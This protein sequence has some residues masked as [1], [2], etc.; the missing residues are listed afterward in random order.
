MIKNKKGQTAL[1]LILLTAV[2]LVFL[3]ITLNWGR[4]AQTKALLT[5]AAD[6]TASLLA[7]D[8]A[9]YGEMWKQTY[10]GNHNRKSNIDYQIILDIILVVIAI[11]ITITTYGGAYGLAAV[12]LA[13]LVA[14]LV[15]QLAVIQPGME[16]MWNKQ[17][18]DQP[19]YQQFYEGGITQALQSI[20]AD[21]VN[22][23]DYF[24]SNSNGI[25]GVN[26]STNPASPNDT[27]NRFAFFYNERLKMLNQTTSM[28]QVGFFYNQLGEFVNGESCL[29][30]AENV[31]QYPGVF[32][33]NPACGCLGAYC[34]QDPIDPV[35]QMKIPDTI[36]CAQDA[37]AASCNSN[38]VLNS[39]CPADC[40][41]ANP[42]DPACQKLIGTGFQLNDQCP[43]NSDPNSATYNPYC[44]P[45][46]QQLSVPDPLYSAGNPLHSQPNISIRP[47][48]CPQDTSAYG[49][50]AQCLTNN[51]YGGAASQ[52]TL[53]YDPTYQ[54]YANGKSFLAQFGRDQQ[55]PT[56]GEPPF[57]GGLTTQGLFPNG[58]YPFFWL[59]KDY[60]P[61]VD[62]ILAT[63]SL[64]A[65]QDHWCVAGKT[66]TPLNSGTAVTVPSVLTPTGY[67][68]L[69]QLTDLSS[70]SASSFQ[71]PY[72]CSGLDCCVNYL[73]AGISGSNVLASSINNPVTITV[74]GQPGLVVTLN[75]PAN[76][77]SYT[78]GGSITFSATATETIPAALP[79]R[80]TG[81][82]FQDFQDNGNTVS[83]PVGTF[84]ATD[85]VTGSVDT[86]T[87]SGSIVIPNTATMGTFT[88]TATAT[89]SYGASVTSSS[90]LITISPA[91]TGTGTGTGVGTGTG[92]SVGTDTGTVVGTDTG[93][94]VDTDTGVMTG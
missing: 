91:A 51:P 4:I 47:S 71:L 30:N 22:I 38:V 88:I 6:Q 67:V 29:Q 93:T 81:I 15:L 48:N 75:S 24:D 79:G 66:I 74:V 45:C 8:A 73:A 7:S 23:T 56:S 13:M 86:Y 84:T 40:G 14:N 49:A 5:I 77:S 1:I 82:T 80:I 87:Y 42:T 83:G 65:S 57:S 11:I 50:P 55:M 76:G 89:D 16:K 64:T 3:A 19:I 68:D 10:L 35:C 20:V 21:Q 44:D 92:T 12:A 62:T 28:P 69:A 58:I 33:V 90:V 60:S 72:T 25:F 43:A 36:T 53:L 59:M 2:A 37:K 27:V 63:S 78:I 70:A 54:N 34:I 52:Y 41:G 9:S 17:M 94:S 85:T 46:C 18:Q 26:W 32:K 39:S 31:S 61:E